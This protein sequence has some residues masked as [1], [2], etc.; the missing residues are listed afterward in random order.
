METLGVE[1]PIITPTEWVSPLATVVKPNK[2]R[3]C[4]DPKDLNEAAK[5]QYYP[6]KTVEDVPTRLP[7]AIVFSTSDALSVFWQI[8]LDEESSFLNCFNT[9]FGRSMH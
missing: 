4:I 9:P 2:I 3:L 7:G 6:T 8:P 1:S 5:R